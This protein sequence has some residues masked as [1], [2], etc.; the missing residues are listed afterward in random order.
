MTTITVEVSD[1]GEYIIE[2][3]TGRVFDVTRMVTDDGVV[4]SKHRRPIEPDA[5][6]SNED[7]HLQ[8]IVAEARTPEALA[9]FRTIQEA[10]EADLRAG[11]R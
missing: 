6:V 11:V 7:P 10:N 1:A 4:M 9:R 5:D 2:K 8:R 3:D